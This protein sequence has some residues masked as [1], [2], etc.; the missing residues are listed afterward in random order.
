MAN[1]KLKIMK[2]NS[3]NSLKVGTVVVALFTLAAT[4]VRAELED[5]V[6]NSFKVQ[7]GG[8]LVVE[9]DRGSIEVMTAD[10]E[11]VDVEVVRT[12]YDDS[13]AKAEKI[14]KD[15]VV[16]MTQHGNRVEIHGKYNGEKPTSWFNFSKWIESGHELKVQYQI[17]VPHKFDVDLKTSGGKIAVDTLTGKVEAHT[18][19]GSLKFEK[20]EGSLSGHTSGGSITV[21]GCKGPVDV[22]TSGGSLHLKD[23]EGDVD[24]HTSGGSI[25][26]DNLTGKS[27]LA[28]SGGSIHVAE[29][30]GQLEAKTSGGGI[31][32]ELV[33][34]PTGDCSFKTS[35]GSITLLLGEKVAVD[36]DAHT[37]A[38]RVSSDFPIATVIQ[39]EH[40]KN[41]L[42]GKINGGGPLI[43]AHTSAGGIHIRK[44]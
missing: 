10:N 14:L 16:T 15:H 32:A 11:S 4:T 37:S 27:E 8:Q 44:K 29:I 25:H 2:L 18:S 21:G 20:I 17:T 36:I 26:A 9:V 39:G 7:P 31:E 43:T 38:G 30:K 35:G 1:T 12:V 41:E 24:A 23:I 28:T 19:G 3:R 6:T 13:E 22:K 34:Q 42:H 5:T 33:G 40:K